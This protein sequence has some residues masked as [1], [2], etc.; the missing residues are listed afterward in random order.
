MS[1]N[2]YLGTT[3]TDSLQELRYGLSHCNNYAT[4]W[5]FEGLCLDSGQ[6]D[7]FLCSPHCPAVVL[8]QSRIESVPWALS[9]G[10]SIDHSPATSAEVKMCVCVCLHIRVHHHSV[11]WIHAVRMKLMNFISSVC[12]KHSHAMQNTPIS[13]TDADQ[14]TTIP[15]TT[16]RNDVQNFLKK[17][18][19]QTSIFA[20]DLTF[21]I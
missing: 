6:G 10:G 4:G 8:P 16:N 15:L 13:R 3:F 7:K 12:T 19:I 20:L 18:L 17:S 9:P 21:S 5:M 11:M 14:L 1:L 2:L